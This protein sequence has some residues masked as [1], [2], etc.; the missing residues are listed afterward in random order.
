MTAVVDEL[1]SLL[2]TA[3]SC[4]VEK[5]WRQEPGASL[6]VMV[7]PAKRGTERGIGIGN[8]WDQAFSVDVMIEA[9]WN[10]TEDIAE[11]VDTTVEA[12]HTVVN[13][14]RTLGTVVAVK[15]KVTDT[16]YLFVA[17]AYGATQ[18]TRWYYG[19]RVTVECTI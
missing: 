10:D 7:Q 8:V 18:Q 14:N 13:A 19:A 5:Y 6:K 1:T 16:A 9:P 12:V 2:R 3:L 15:M 17:R 4:P 11:S